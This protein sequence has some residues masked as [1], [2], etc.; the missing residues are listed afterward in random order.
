[1]LSVT[2]KISFTHRPCEPLLVASIWVKQQQRPLQPFRRR[3]LHHA[4]RG[5]LRMESF[6]K[7][8]PLENLLQLAEVALE[9]QLYTGKMIGADRRLVGEVGKLGSSLP[10]AGDWLWG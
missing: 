8:L 9:P 7:I 10:F 5:V 6:E 1:M 4:R 2:E 3:R